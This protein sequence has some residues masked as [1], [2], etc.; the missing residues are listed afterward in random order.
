MAAIYPEGTLLTGG[1]SK[2]RSSGG[3]QLGAVILPEMCPEELSFGLE[4]IAATIY[5][6]V[7]TPVQNAAVQA[8]TASS[9]FE[10]FL[11]S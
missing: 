8:Y 5:T 9:E 10:K 3:Y 11:N 7:T 6:N 2:D 1:L 4:K